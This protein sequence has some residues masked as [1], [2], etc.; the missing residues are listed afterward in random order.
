MIESVKKLK[1]DMVEDE[2][3]PEERLLVHDS[4]EYVQL[5]SFEGHGDGM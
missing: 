4:L 1:E 5:T 3:S 2:E